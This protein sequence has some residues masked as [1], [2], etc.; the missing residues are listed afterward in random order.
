MRV[1]GVS[2]RCLVHSAQWRPPIH[3]CSTSAT[4]NSPTG[5]VI[6]HDRPWRQELCVDAASESLAEYREDAEGTGSG[7]GATARASQVRNGCHGERKIGNLQSFG[8]ECKEQ[9]GRGGLRIVNLNRICQTAR[10]EC[11]TIYDGRGNDTLPKFLLYIN[12]ADYT[13]RRNDAKNG[14]GHPN[15]DP[16]A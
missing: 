8:M 5:T 16:F 1:I 7:V 9:V 2:G 4:H 10:I 6:F 12:H 3:I 11:N 15:T 14:L 13:G